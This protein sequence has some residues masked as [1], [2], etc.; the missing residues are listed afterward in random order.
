ME[1][2]VDASSLAERRDRIL[3]PNYFHSFDQPLHLIKGDGV[4][5]WD[6][7]GRKYLDCYNNV[8]C[9]GHCHPRVVAA[10]CDQTRLL[11][12]HTRYLH[13]NIVLLAEHLSATLP[14][15]LDAVNLVCSGSEAN[16]LAVQMA[17]AATGNQGILAVK[18]AYHG[19]T[20]LAKALSTFE[21]VTEK[22]PQG[23]PDWLSVFEGP[24]PYRG[25]FREDT[26]DIGAK[27]AALVGDALDALLARGHKPAA[28]ILDLSFDA[29]GVLAAPD[30]YVADVCARVK[31]AGGLLIVDEVQAGHGRTGRMWGFETYGIVPDL[32]TMGKSMGGGYPVAAM[33]TTREIA[34]KFVER[35]SYFNTFGGNPVASA[36][37]KAVLEVI[38][39]EDLLAR[40]RD[41]GPYLEAGLRRLNARYDFIGTVQGLGTFW[42]LDLVK[43]PHIR[44]PLPASEVSRILTLLASQGVI[45]GVQG[46]HDNIIKIRP[47]LVFTRDHAD[48]CL[49]ALDAVFSGV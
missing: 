13:E 21:S 22:R 5:L 24:N 27:Y 48:L 44:E 4:W 45:A 16:D 36:A 41:V 35:D 18:R 15:G 30:G 47:P 25:P 39:E 26:P 29:D 28:L 3:A 38:E 31:K 19:S 2:H 23:M 43:D 49:Q 10:V 14:P 20:T 37:A 8:P 9:V 33:V 1:A 34:G 46:V 7:A 11:S 42:G 12:T 40:V 6:S 32:V 17:R